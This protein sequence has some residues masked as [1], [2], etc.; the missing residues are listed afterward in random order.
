MHVFFNF[1]CKPNCPPGIL[2]LFKIQS[3]SILQSLTHKNVCINLQ[4]SSIKTLIYNFCKT[5][6]LQH[7]I[8]LCH[9]PICSKNAQFL[10][11]KHTDLLCRAVFFCSFF[12][13]NPTSGHTATFCWQISI[14][15]I[16]IG[17]VMHL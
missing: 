15:I 2:K 7:S 13:D 5:S 1:C 9:C 11:A 16:K 17:K 14:F 3:Q 4:N 12:T 8:Y 6:V 10:Y